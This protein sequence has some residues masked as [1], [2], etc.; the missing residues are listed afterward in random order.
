M[1]IDIGWT[2]RGIGRGTSGQEDVAEVWGR[3]MGPSKEEVLQM[4]WRA[5]YMERMV[6]GNHCRATASEFLR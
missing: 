5:V 3:H 4:I 1:S 6:V 2:D